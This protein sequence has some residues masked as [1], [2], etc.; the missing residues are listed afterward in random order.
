MV[1]LKNYK[2]VSDRVRVEDGHMLSSYDYQ[3]TEVDM[4]S[5]GQWE[6]RPKTVGYEFKTDLKVP[7]LG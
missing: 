5:E 2:V 6:L 7:K 3:T 4:D 1:L